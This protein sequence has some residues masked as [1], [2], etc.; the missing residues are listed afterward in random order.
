MFTQAAARCDILVNI[1]NHQ[2]TN[3]HRT[4]KLSVTEAVNLLTQ[5]SVMEKFFNYPY[6]HAYALRKPVS[7]NATNLRRIAYFH[8]VVATYESAEASSPLAISYSE[9]CKGVAAFC[10]DMY[11]YGDEAASL[12]VH[13]V[14]HLRHLV[15]STQ[16]GSEVTLV[17]H[18]PLTM[19]THKEEIGKFL[20]N[21]FHSPTTWG[22]RNEIVT[23]QVAVNSCESI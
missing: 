18:F 11:F 5:Q 2:V 10:Q 14:T 7:P 21:L 3:S 13:T 16:P 23:A 6:I 9:I 12:R 17:L 19:N 1:E 20:E 8:D 4:K 15:Q 22:Y